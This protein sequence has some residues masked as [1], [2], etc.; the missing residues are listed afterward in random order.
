MANEAAVTGCYGKR[1]WP[2][3]HGCDGLANL[4]PTRILMAH[5]RAVA[6]SV[7]ELVRW[8]ATDGAVV[9]E[10]DVR[11]PGFQSISRTPGQVIHDVQGRFEDALENVRNAAASAL[12]KFQDGVL[13]PDGVEIEFG[14]KFNA[15]AGAVIAKTSAEG[16]LAVKLTW[17]R[18]AGS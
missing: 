13:D 3:V 11:E 5:G 8:Q 2:L 1:C 9:V 17:S 14:V 18:S 16:H 10:V 15:E 7:N 4:P 6:S 12:K